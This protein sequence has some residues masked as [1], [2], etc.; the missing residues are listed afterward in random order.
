MKEQTYKSMYTWEIGRSSL[1]RQIGP[2]RCRCSCRWRETVSVN[3][4]HLRAYCSAPRWCLSMESYS[5]IILTVKPKNSEENLSQCHFVLHKSHI[6]R[7]RPATNCLSHGTADEDRCLVQYLRKRGW[8]ASRFCLDEVAKINVMTWSSL[9][10]SRK[11][12][13]AGHV[14]T[15][16]SKYEKFLESLVSKCEGTRHIWRP[17]DKL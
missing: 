1:I 11:M 5:G 15:T 4:G 16:Q 17:N 7:P 9:M 2:C 12:V 10:K 8:V 6:D 3:F 13:W 14:A